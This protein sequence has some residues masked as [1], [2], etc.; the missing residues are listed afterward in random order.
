[1]KYTHSLGAFFV[2]DGVKFVLTRKKF[3]YTN[4]FWKPED[5]R[6]YNVYVKESSDGIRHVISGKNFATLPS[7]KPLHQLF[8]DSVKLRRTHLENMREEVAQYDRDVAAKE[9]VKFFASE[10]PTGSDHHFVIHS[11]SSVANCVHEKM[12]LGEV[13]VLMEG[14]RA[15][16]LV[17]RVEIFKPDLSDR[18]FLREAGMLKHAADRDWD[19]IGSGSRFSLVRS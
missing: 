13:V 5:S 15:D 2:V 4:D 14:L 19:E 17:D 11:Y 12:T 3:S 9:G 10:R 8:A 16:E 18:L 7:K 1:M 6:A